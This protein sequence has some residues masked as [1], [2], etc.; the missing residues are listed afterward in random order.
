ME[1]IT[2]E[3]EHRHQHKCGHSSYL[4]DKKMYGIILTTFALLSIFLLA[5]IVTEVKGWRYIGFGIASTNTISVQGEG[6]VFATPDTGVFT[7]SVIKEGKT[8]KVVQNDA[9]EVTNKAIKYLKENG[10]EEKDIKTTVYNVY[11]RYEYKQ[12]SCT[13]YLCPLSER[14]LIGFEINQSTQVK[15]RD[16]SKVGT[17]LSG[18]GSIGVERISSLSFIIDNKDELEQKVKKIAVNDAKRKAE[19]LA[20]DLGVRL[21][22]I[23]NFN[24][25]KSP[26]FSKLEYQTSGVGSDTSVIPNIP[27]G[28]NSFVSK[29]NITYEI[30]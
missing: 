16:T 29:V 20:K 24:E 10:V 4:H 25:F 3:N 23:V 30:R 9:T 27:T 12:R 2:N 22:R 21:V 26:R 11:P 15:V 7:F 6:K 19:V 1:N 18:I 13:T 28:E 14:K 5:S 17:L 8:A